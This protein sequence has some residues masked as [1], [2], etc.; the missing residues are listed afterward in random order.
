MSRA[1]GPED[2]TVVRSPRTRLAVD[3]LSPEGPDE[4]VTLPLVSPEPADSSI[5]P[6][7]PLALLPVSTR[8]SPIR[9][10]SPVWKTTEPDCTPLPE[11]IPLR[12]RT[13]TAPEAPSAEVPPLMDSAPP[14][15]FTELPALTLRSPPGEVELESPPAIST[16]PP[17]SLDPAVNP[18][19]ILI[20]PPADLPAPV[21]AET[22][23]LPPNPVS[24][25]PE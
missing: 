12:V 25:E 20:E 17:T 3:P 16:L 22:S 4:I 23:T 13:L 1:P 15:P 2:S 19:R 8:I 5:L 7:S 21:P 14:G 11:V 10:A 18:P 24:P 6:P 9:D